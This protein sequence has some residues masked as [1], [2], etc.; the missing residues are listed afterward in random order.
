MDGRM[1]GLN[2]DVLC[3]VSDRLYK[4][5][6]EIEARL[7]Q[8]EQE[9]FSLEESIILYDIT[10]TYFEWLALGNEK[11]EYGYSRDHRPDQKQVVVGLVLDVEGFPKAHTVFEGSKRDP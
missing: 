11:A 9:L 4:N 3:R 5:R 10:L 6:E 8:R 7:S 2:E 1:K